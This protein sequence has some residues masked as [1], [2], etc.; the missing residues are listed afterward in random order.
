[1]KLYKNNTQPIQKK[2]N[3]TGLPDT[4][5]SGIEN[6]SGYAMDDVKVHYNS[7]KPAQLNAHA[8]AQGTDIH[9]AS[10]Q[11][12]HLPHEAW[13]VVQQKQ[14]RVRP[15]TQL[16]GPSTSL[17]NPVNI[18][19]D[20]GLEREADV[21][22]EKALS[23]SSVN[24]MRKLI[25]SNKYITPLQRKGERTAV[26]SSRDTTRSAGEAIR[27]GNRR[28][29]ITSTG[30]KSSAKLNI[31]YDPPH[32]AFSTGYRNKVN[33]LRQYVKQRMVSSGI[34][35][36]DQ[37]NNLIDNNDTFLQAKAIEEI[38]VGNC[39]EFSMVVF[40]H[41]VQ[42]TNNQWVYRAR[43]NGLVLGTNKEYDHAFAFTSSQDIAVI[44]NVTDI[45]GV[46]KNTAT[47]ADAWDGYQVMTL[48]QFVNGGNAYKTQLTNDNVVILEKKVASGADVFNP[49]IKGY[50]T[51]WAVQFNQ[52]FNQ[53]MLVNN[54][55]YKTVADSRAASP[56]GFNTRGSDVA[57]IDD[58]R[59]FAQKYE[60][61]TDQEKVQII[62]EVSNN[63]LFDYLNT[64]SIEE[65][66]TLLNKLSDDV[67]LAYINNCWNK[68]FLQS[69]ALLSKYPYKTEVIT[70]LPRNR[71]YTILQRMQLV[72]RRLIMNSLSK[73]IQDE[74]EEEAPPIQIRID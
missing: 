2:E 62:A 57:G 60:N 37:A 13:H 29:S 63:D 21:M 24:V 58:K 43:M 67:V 22:G 70:N 16:R 18:N 49:I 8:Y 48:L 17:R 45:D 4:L 69:F 73:T 36:Q 7:D 39:G 52:E 32:Q 68:G 59:T 71:A 15:T 38:S 53:Q 33:E 31:T 50:I 28:N 46:D 66:V 12:K 47:I 72:D 27:R 20:V 30:G 10:G 6:L 64:L 61:S 42:N 11:E 55:V 56:T 54:S 35:T 19:D 26:E 65:K 40:A 14:G 25:E 74:I 3:N 41:L 34:Y 23:M 5:K 1:L 51:D 9:L 44:P